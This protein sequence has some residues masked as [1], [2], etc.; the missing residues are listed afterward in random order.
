[1]PPPPP[2]ALPDELLEEIFLRLQPDEPA[3][4][5]R[6]SLASKSWFA[7]LTGA[8]FR[9]LYRDFH[10]APPMLGFIYR[11]P[12][13]YVTEEE[14][15]LPHFKATANFGA[16]IPAV[17]DW[18]GWHRGY[19][20]WDCRHGRVLFANKNVVPMPLVVWDPMT[21]RRRLLHPPQDYDSSG[22]AVLCNV[23]GCDHRACHMGP[24]QVVFIGMYNTDDSTVAYAHV[25]LPEVVNW[26]EPCTFDLAAED[27]FMVD[28]PP[29]FIQD[30]LYFML[31]YGDYDGDGGDDKTSILKYHLGSNC[32]SLIDAPPVKT[33]LVDGVVIMAMEDAS[34]GF[35]HVDRITLNLWAR[36]MGS[37]GVMSWTQRRVINLENLLPIQ[38]PREKHRLIGSVEGSDIIFV[39]TDL[40]IYEINLKTLRWKEIWKRENCHALFPYLSFYNPPARVNLADAAH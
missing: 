39:T 34:L 3:C 27:A 15:S 4:L 2:P 24:F 26:S 7:L 6:A 17:E 12:P 40:D 14:D 32:L 22:A 29:V 16:C 10:G 23:T 18:K 19:D 33:G 37:N 8:R 31:A 36:Y 5:V 28:R 11:C 20:A 21:G 25:S 9:G 35:A 30:A 13:D 38:N 1:M